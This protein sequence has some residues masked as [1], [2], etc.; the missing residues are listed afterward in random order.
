MSIVQL[1]QNEDYSVVTGGTGTTPG[2]EARASAST[3]AAAGRQLAALFAAVSAYA[4][5]ESS[6]WIRTAPDSRGR[7]HN[8]SG[9]PAGASRWIT[10][11]VID[12]LS[13][14]FLPQASEVALYVSVRSLPRLAVDFSWQTGLSATTGLPPAALDAEWRTTGAAS[15]EEQARNHLQRFETLLEE[16]AGVIAARDRDK[17]VERLRRLWQLSLDDD[18]E[19]E[20]LSLDSLSDLVSFLR[21]GAP[22]RT[23]MLVT[24]YSGHLVAEWRASSAWRASAE[25][26]GNRTVAY[27][28]VSADRLRPARLNRIEG[29]V[30]AEDL[31]RM[32][33]R[34]GAPLD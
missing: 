20:P 25:F 13:A 8:P 4:A 5:G 1:E 27:F 21:N 22:A 31:G 18:P 32:L 6:P 2:I 16:A 29:T 23:P 3:P 28:T 17:F 34:L 7:D 24:T 12:Q 19:Q 10:A 33:R 30:S 15:A 9:V 11:L 14:V 26:T